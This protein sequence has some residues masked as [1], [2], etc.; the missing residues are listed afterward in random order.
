VSDEK[1]FA[2]VETV[3]SSILTPFN[4]SYITAKWKFT[5]R[6][7][8]TCTCSVTHMHTNRSLTC[9]AATWM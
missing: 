8:N 9:Q 7:A 4:T 6:S 5:F 1:L 2:N 3:H